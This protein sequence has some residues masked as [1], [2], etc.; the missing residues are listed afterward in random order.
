[1]GSTCSAATSAS[2][3]NEN[4]IYASINA[5]HANES[6]RTLDNAGH[7]LLA[8]VSNFTAP[9][10][11]N[12]PLASYGGFIPAGLVTRVYPYALT[13]RQSLAVAQSY[14]TYAFAYQSYASAAKYPIATA[15]P[16]G[17]GTIYQWGPGGFD[18]S[19]ATSGFHQPQFTAATSGAL[20]LADLGHGLL[21]LERAGGSY[22]PTAPSSPYQQVFRGK[23][24]LQH[25]EDALHWLL[26]PA[27]IAALTGDE[28]NTNRTL[29]Y[30]DAYLLMG[31]AALNAGDTV[32]G[33]A[34]IAQSGTFMAKAL[35]SACT[36][37]SNESFWEPNGGYVAGCP[38]RQPAFDSSYQGVSLMYLL[39][40]FAN[41]PAKGVT[42]P[43]GAIQAPAV[44]SAI[45]QGFSQ[46][47]TQIQYVNAGKT[48]APS[49]GWCYSPKNAAF[50]DG[51]V[52][53][54]LNSRVQGLGCAVT[55]YGDAP[56]GEVFDGI[57]ISTALEE[58]AFFPG[59][60]NA[61]TVNIADQVARYYG[62]YNINYECASDANQPF[63]L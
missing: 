40:Y 4:A 12:A 16:N 14:V 39:W 56:K 42:Y 41:M 29:R 20:F 60:G 19:Y 6:D 54:C 1:M 28:T 8:D 43:G 63:Y 22:S 15:D 49:P 57:S 45:K 53:E 62:T 5:S 55:P 36:K 32:D 9:M 2:T 38:A 11:Q 7:T 37:G 13:N 31:K 52:S 35:R 48:H 17:G 23:T 10:P 26:Q 34:A 51:E 24:Y 46:E 50:K 27:Q 30:A 58:Y 33:C 3:W 59:G 47:I 44:W 25:A 18:T 21:L 61:T